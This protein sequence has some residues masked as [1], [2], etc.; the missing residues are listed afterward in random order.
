MVICTS[1]AIVLGFKLLFIILFSR[2]ILYAYDSYVAYQHLEKVT[3]S[4]S[5]LKQDADPN[6]SREPMLEDDNTIF[7]K[8]YKECL[9]INGHFKGKYKRKKN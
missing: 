1:F 9:D 5:Y 2:L 8:R 3:K 6:A 4:I 7:I